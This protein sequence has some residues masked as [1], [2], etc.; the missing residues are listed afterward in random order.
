MSKGKFSTWEDS[1]AGVPQ[2]SIL[3][4]LLFNIFINDLFLF[5]SN[6][7]LSNYADD[8]TLYAFGYN[9]EE[10]KNTLRF[11]FDLV[12]KWFEENY[13][14]L[15]ADK[16]HFMCLGKDTENETFIFNNFI[17]NNSNEEKILGITIDN[18]LTFK[19]HIKILCRK[20]AQKMGALSRLLNHLSDSQKRSI[21][22]SLIKSQFNYCPLIWM[23][24]SRTSNNIITIIHEQ[25]LRLILN[26]QTSDFDTH[27]QN[28]NGTC[29]H[30][31]IIQTLMVDVYKIK[32]NLNPPIMN[33]LFE[34]RNNTY[35]FRNFQEVNKKKKNCKDG[36]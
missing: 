24:C 33:F 29:N 14:V 18:K 12:S 22:N 10:I 32:N 27:L 36:S 3:G 19:G 35:N 1:I 23:F 26:G 16:C 28:N 4:P 21:F 17:F 31:R 20:A 13:M 15:N 34:R 2:G 7:Y 6:S 8:N 11:D 9:L 30:H 25:V 5:V